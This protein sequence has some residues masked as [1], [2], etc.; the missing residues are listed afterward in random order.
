MTVVGAVVLA[1]CSSPDESVTTSARQALQS[2]NGAWRAI[3]RGRGTQLVLHAAHSYT[4]ALAAQCG[5]DYEV[6]VVVDFGPVTPE[7]LEVDGVTATFRPAEGHAVVPR[8]LDVW[9]NLTADKQILDGQVRGA[10]ES[11]RYD[12]KR[13][14]VLDPKDPIVVLE[15]ESAGSLAPTSVACRQLARFVFYPQGTTAPR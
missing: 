15:L 7:I 1:G 9:S 8:K 4:D 5:P 12:V 14:Y 2:D 10:G 13:A 6:D 11:V 3:P